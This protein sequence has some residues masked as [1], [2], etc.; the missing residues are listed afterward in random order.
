MIL[1]AAFL[2]QSTAQIAA[3]DGLPIPDVVGVPAARYIGCIGDP[4]E[5]AMTTGQPA[6]PAARKALVETALAGCRSVRAEVTAE[7]DAKLATMP[8]WTDPAV[9]TAKIARMLDA[10]EER[11]AFTVVDNEGF[12]AMADSMMKCRNA[13]RKDCAKDMPALKPSR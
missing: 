11:V 13:G 6:D 3:W 8:G 9:R 5:E 7:M 4:V 10:A 2:L 12:R 1:L